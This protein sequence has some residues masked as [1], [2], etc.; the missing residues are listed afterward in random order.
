MH[1]NCLQTLSA[2]A[3]KACKIT[4]HAKNQNF[5]CC[6]LLEVTL[7]ANNKQQIK[8]KRVSRFVC[9]VNF[10]AFWRFCMCIQ[11]I[12]PTRTTG[13]GGGQIVGVQESI[14]LC[15]YLGRFS[16]QLS[17]QNN[18]VTE[19]LYS[20]FIFFCN[21]LFCQCCIYVLK[22]LSAYN[23][24]CIFT[25]AFHTLNKNVQRKNV[26]IFLPISFNMCFGCTKE[27]SH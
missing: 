7:M 21:P 18:L 17:V 9:H 2:D 27:R 14:V 13:E 1:P 10:C 16:C 4:Q 5:V 15:L 24:Y 19:R 25:N 3:K 26:N 20:L 12:L 11:K 8:L 22:F 6:K 23:I